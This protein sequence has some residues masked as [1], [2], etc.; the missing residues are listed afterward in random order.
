M[1]MQKLLV[2]AATVF[3]TTAGAA[4]ANTVTDTYTITES[5]F[6]SGYGYNEPS[7]YDDLGMGSSNPLNLT[8]SSTNFFVASPSGSCGKESS[9]SWPN[10]TQSGTLNVT[11]DFTEYN[12]SN[13]IIATGSLTETATY[14]AKYSGTDLGCSGKNGSGQTDC[15]DWTGAATGVGGSVTIPVA[16]GTTTLDV[17]LYNAQDWSI[18]PKISFT[19]QYGTS[20]VP[21]PATLPLFASGLGALGLLGWHRKRKAVAAP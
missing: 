15:I 11:M 6:G 10:Y 19:E 8:G 20:P 9:C 1:R 4:Y 2:T 18:T 3:L 5:G 12:S 16:L 13:A 17:T 14:T 7:I 21:L